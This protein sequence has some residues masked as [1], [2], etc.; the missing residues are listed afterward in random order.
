MKLYTFDNWKRKT[1]T[2]QE[3]ELYEPLFEANLRKIKRHWNVI[4]AGANIGLYT[5]LMARMANEG[6]VFA[7]ECHPLVVDILSK[8]VKLH[9]LKNVTI[10]RRALSDTVGQKVELEESTT[11][12]G[13][14]VDKGEYNSANIQLA[15][16]AISKLGLLR[17]KLL[18]R[19]KQV[20]L[21]ETD[22]LDNLFYK[23]IRVDLIK[24]DIQGMENKALLRGGLRLLKHDRPIL[25]VEVHRRRYFSQEKFLT[26]LRGMGYKLTVKNLPKHPTA[27]SVVGEV[28]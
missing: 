28:V 24:M 23:K 18:G 10:V 11:S 9:G 5:V 1:I 14:S 26:T 2:L 21:T 22:T 3:Q 8:N 7:I 4:D 6:H 16:R 19:S 27:L 13:T 17:R 15:D 20:G 25:L 12:E